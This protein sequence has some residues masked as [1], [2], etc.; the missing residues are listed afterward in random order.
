MIIPQELSLHISEFSGAPELGVTK[1]YIL[2]EAISLDIS[3]SSIEFRAKAM[4]LEHLLRYICTPLN[5]GIDLKRYQLQRQYG[6]HQRLIDILKSNECTI[7][8]TIYSPD[9]NE[10]AVLEI[11]GNVPSLKEL[12]DI[13]HISVNGGTHYMEITMTLEDGDDLIRL[14]YL[15]EAIIDTPINSFR[16]YIELNDEGIDHCP[17]QD[18]IHRLLKEST[19]ITTAQLL[20]ECPDIDVMLILRSQRVKYEF[21]QAIL[22]G[23]VNMSYLLKINEILQKNRYIIMYNIPSSNECDITPY[24]HDEDGTSQTIKCEGNTGT[25]STLIQNELGCTYSNPLQDFRC[26]LE[27]VKRCHCRLNQSRMNVTVEEYQGAYVNPMGTLDYRGLYPSSLMDLIN[28]YP[29]IISSMD[30]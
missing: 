6:K 2:Q 12:E 5:L 26:I 14:A 11:T 22:E 23:R 30:H 18:D 13:P 16:G 15:S 27:L 8:M 28:S 20:K 4:G 10:R 7:A 21:I 29:S 24:D 1:D 19:N 3:Y 17:L 25:I 9:P